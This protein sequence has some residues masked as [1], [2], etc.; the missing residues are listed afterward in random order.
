M[1]K[2]SIIAIILSIT[3]LSL[4]IFIFASSA[5][6]ETNPAK[7]KTSSS[8]TIYYAPEIPDSLNFAGEGVPLDDLYVREAIDRE[9][10]SIAYRHSA[11]ILTMKRAYRYFPVIEPILKKNGVPLDFKYLC[12]IESELTNATSPAKAQGFWQFMKATGTSYG[13]EVN[14][15][16]DM[17]NNLEA[18]TLAACKYLKVLKRD[19]GSW[20]SAAAAYNCGEGGLRKRLNE[21]GVTSYY[22]TYIFTETTRYVPRILAMKTIMGNPQKYG[23]MLRHCDMYPQLKYK[24]VE[25]KGQNV[26][27]AAFAKQNNTNL[28]VL[29]NLNPWITTNKLTNK[30]N[31]TYTIKIPD[32]DGTSFS[33]MQK[34]DD[35]KTDFITRL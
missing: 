33:K 9:L 29:R 11:T 26:D 21:Q 34:S 8:M 30:A 2:L 6:N 28:K 3:T 1:K 18:A 24:T 23:F 13:L 17:R 27:L 15:E 4:Q 32:S 20:T 31:K 35:K 14:D 7:E 22:D 10:V 16:I 12:V 25:L 19:L 5:N